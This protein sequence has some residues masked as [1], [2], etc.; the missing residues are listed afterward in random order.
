MQHARLDRQVGGM[1]LEARCRQGR[2][3]P[4][5]HIRGGADETD[6]RTLRTMG[7]WSRLSAARGG[8]SLLRFAEP[9]PAEAGSGRLGRPWDRGRFRSAS[10]AGVRAPAAE[11]GLADVLLLLLLLLLLLG[12]DAPTLCPAAEDM[13]TGRG[14]SPFNSALWAWMGLGRGRRK[15]KK[16]NHNNKA[17]N[18]IFVASIPGFELGCRVSGVQLRARRGTG[19]VARRNQSISDGERDLATWVGA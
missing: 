13:S 3:L 6:A 7:A 9:E 12:R 18:S 5:T 8:R 4:D 1:R 11:E 16:N 14:R 2:C 10:R 19:V 15:R 17:R